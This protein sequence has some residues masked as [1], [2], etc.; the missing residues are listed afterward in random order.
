M[1]NHPN[2]GLFRL[3]W[4]PGK[5]DHPQTQIGIPRP[6]GW[7]RARSIL[8]RRRKNRKCSEIKMIY[9]WVGLHATTGSHLDDTSKHF[10]FLKSSSISLFL[11]KSRKALVKVPFSISKNSIISNDL[12]AGASEHKSFFCLHIF[13]NIWNFNNLRKKNLIPPWASTVICISKRSFTY[14]NKTQ[15]RFLCY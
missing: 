8:L 7:G 13:D 4:P 5:S 12:L 10:S 3:I 14:K 11:Q 1:K 6:H 15:R 9:P 2:A